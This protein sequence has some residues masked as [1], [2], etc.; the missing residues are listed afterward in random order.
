MVGF[1]LVGRTGWSP[2]IPWKAQAVPIFNLAF[3]REK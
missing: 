3:I 1:G 2:V